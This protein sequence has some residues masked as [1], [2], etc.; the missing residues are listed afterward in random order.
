[1]D[2]LGQVMAHSGLLNWS[3][4]TEDVFVQHHT[5]QPL[6]AIVRLAKLPLIWTPDRSYGS[7]LSY[8]KAASK[9]R[10]L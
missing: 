4:F 1:M 10:S 7:P 6:T 8:R 5:V 2:A 3:K 9:S